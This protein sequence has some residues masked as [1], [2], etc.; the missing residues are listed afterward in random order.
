MKD[1]EAVSNLNS[2]LREEGLPEV[3]IDGLAAQTVLTLIS[4]L[5]S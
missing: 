2:R 1:I 4:K 3:D 5:D